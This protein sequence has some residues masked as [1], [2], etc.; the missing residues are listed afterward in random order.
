MYIDFKTERLNKSTHNHSCIF[1]PFDEGRYYPSPP[2]HSWKDYTR[3][4]FIVLYYF[5]I[6][7]AYT[8][9]SY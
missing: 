6:V 5:A 9:L 8:I 2:H 3:R 1:K 7:H 4:F